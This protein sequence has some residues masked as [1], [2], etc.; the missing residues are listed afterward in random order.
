MA[1]FCY[2]AWQTSLFSAATF[3]VGRL[4]QERFQE[5]FATCVV[6][7]ATGGILPA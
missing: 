6:L 1:L 4:L 2:M 3:F 7:N 5:S